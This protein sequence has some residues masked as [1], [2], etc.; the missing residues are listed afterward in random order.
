MTKQEIAA[1]VNAIRRL[2]DALSG[3]TVADKTEIYEH[4]PHSQ[5]RTYS[6]A[7]R[8]SVV[9]LTPGPGALCR[10]CL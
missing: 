7:G 8:A 10:T 5:P 4:Q 9:A 3:A 2:M 1:A 6:H